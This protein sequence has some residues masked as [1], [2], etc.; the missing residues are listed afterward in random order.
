MV[1]EF[2]SFVSRRTRHASRRGWVILKASV[3]EIKAAR[4][5]SGLSQAK[6]A[7]LIGFSFRSWQSWEQGQRPMR[8]ELLELF[9]L[10]AS[11]IKV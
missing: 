9:K 11:P 3:S 6:A 5:K 1:H 4:R 8:K 2:G 7:E 10:K